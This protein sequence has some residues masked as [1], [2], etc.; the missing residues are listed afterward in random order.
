MTFL[1]PFYDAIMITEGA[2]YFIDRILS[3]IE[4]LLEHTKNTKTRYAEYSYLDRKINIV[5]QK[6]KKYYNKINIT[7]A[8]VDATV[9]NP[10][11]K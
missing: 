7:V 1:Q 6:M 8:Y 10:I 11:F 9:L 3:A 4:F 5:W 2:Y